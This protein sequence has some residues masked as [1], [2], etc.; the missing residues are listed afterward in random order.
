MKRYLDRRFIFCL[1]ALVIILFSFVGPLAASGGGSHEL[2]R[3][4]DRFV[5]D[6]A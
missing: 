2:C 6:R 3:I 5:P 1:A 4:G